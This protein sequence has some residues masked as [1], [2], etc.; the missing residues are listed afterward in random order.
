MY[1]YMCTYLTLSG[2]RIYTV[3]IINAKPHTGLV[4]S[5]FNPV[6]IGYFCYHNALVY[7]PPP[8]P[9]NIMGSCTSLILV[10]VVIPAIYKISLFCLL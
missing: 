8:P 3:N 7:S 6:H 1:L 9:P 4:L 2:N 5:Q 10:L